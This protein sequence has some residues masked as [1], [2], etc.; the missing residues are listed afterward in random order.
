VGVPP[1]ELSRSNPRPMFRP[2]APLCLAALV[3]LAATDA[4]PAQ[5]RGEIEYQ[6]RSLPARMQSQLA[7][8]E[9]QDAKIEDWSDAYSTK[10]KHYRIRTTVPH[11]IVELEIKPFLD[12]LYDAYIASFRDDFGLSGKGANFKT[13]CIYHGYDE[14]FAETG[15]PRTNPGYIVNRDELHV[16]YDDFEPDVFYDTTYHEGA[17][18][19][20]GAMMPGAKL[21]TWL[22]EALATWFEGCS[23]SRSRGEFVVGHYP[24]SRVRLAQRELANAGASPD[25]ARLFMDVPK[26]RFLAPQYALAWSF[27]VYL[28]DREDGLGAQKFGELL[29]ALNG[30]GAKDFADVFAEVSTVP[31]AELTEGWKDFVM[32]I[33]EPETATWVILARGDLPAEIDI[34]DDDRL[35]SVAGQSIQNQQGLGRICQELAY[36]ADPIEVVCVRKNTTERGYTMQR[37]TTTLQPPQL[38]ELLVRGTEPRKASLID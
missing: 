31:L 35:V 37:V 11:F 29:Q 15:R 23:W 25:P 2:L 13:I 10:T 19:F 26:P 21:P 17:H 7:K 3:G 27:V 4:L 20:F 30:S 5:G 1:H 33:P 8:W 38:D 14:Y 32:A 22:D 28:V 34:Q 24:P 6:G 9:K 36:T 16:F 12:A 18:Q